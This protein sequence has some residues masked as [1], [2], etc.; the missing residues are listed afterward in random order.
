MDF[1]LHGATIKKNNRCLRSRSLKTAK[2]KV[3]ASVEI[4]CNKN[5][6]YSVILDALSISK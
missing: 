4:I 2:E 5:A 1:R 6:L 3:R